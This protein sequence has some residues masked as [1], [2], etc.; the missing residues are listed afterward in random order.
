MPPPNKTSQDAA[1][2]TR[3]SDAGPARATV[4][5]HQKSCIQRHRRRHRQQFA[6]RIFGSLA[7]CQRRAGRVSSSTPS[8]SVITA[9]S[10]RLPVR[11]T[12]PAAA[13]RPDPPCASRS[14]RTHQRRVPTAASRTHGCVPLGGGGGGGRARGGRAR[15]GGGGRAPPSPPRA[16]ADG[17]AWAAAQARAMGGNKGGKAKKGGPEDWNL[18]DAD[19]ALLAA[20][21]SGDL[22]AARTALAA[23][24]KLNC[25]VR[26]CVL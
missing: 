6:S 5:V 12:Q 8:S 14:T 3:E 13:A 18:T 21:Q 10:A 7:F 4:C 11:R 23:G 19:E 16:G 2:R 20:A 24:A 15:G 26:A 9:L 1:A 25:Y 22:E 17:S